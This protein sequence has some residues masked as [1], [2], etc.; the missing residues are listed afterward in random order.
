MPRCHG[1]YWISS[2]IVSVISA[3]LHDTHS[4]PSDHRDHH[5]I[6]NV[7]VAIAFTH[8]TIAHHAAHAAA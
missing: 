8:D 1:A 4:A 7:L 2:G 6:P 3:S 5:S